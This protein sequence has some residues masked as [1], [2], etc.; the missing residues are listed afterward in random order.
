MRAIISFRTTLQNHQ[1]ETGLRLRDALRKILRDAGF[2][3]VRLETVNH[4]EATDITPAQLAEALQAFWYTA[5]NP[6]PGTT[7]GARLD[8]LWMCCDDPG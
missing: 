6:P 5:G 2:E 3:P 7:S 4:Y 8:H 1:D